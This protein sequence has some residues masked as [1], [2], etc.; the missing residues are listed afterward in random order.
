[1]TDSK[2]TKYIKNGSWY[3]FW[4]KNFWSVAYDFNPPLA[5]FAD[6][7]VHQA[8]CADGH[9]Q[10]H[11]A[12][13]GSGFFSRLPGH[14]ELPWQP[15]PGCSQ[16]VQ[17]SEAGRVRH[18]LTNQQSLCYCF[19]DLPWDSPKL[20]CH[21]SHVWAWG[22][23]CGDRYLNIFMSF[24]PILFYHLLRVVCCALLCRCSPRVKQWCRGSWELQLQ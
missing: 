18:F 21:L 7:L 6:E 14:L 1:M 15:H 13:D 17:H 10:H 2:T 24:D 19:K 11:R 9:L 20:Y 23:M 3:C 8:G 5:S 16:H 4:Y 22:Q 12:G